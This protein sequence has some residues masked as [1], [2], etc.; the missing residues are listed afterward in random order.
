MKNEPRSIATRFRAYQLGQ[1]GSSFSHYANGHF[2]LIEGIIT[3]TNHQTLLDELK[4]CGKF[5]IDTL[6]ITS[7]DNDHCNNAAL[8]WIFDNLKPKRVEY[9]GY[10]PHTLT[11]HECRNT[12]KSYKK[13]FAAKGESITIQSIDPNYV[14]ALNKAQN[15]GYRD[16]VYHP[17][18]LYEDSNN[19]STIK[20][21]RCGSF[22]VLSLGD[23]KD[24]NISAMLRRCKILCREID[25]MILA[26][27]GADNGFTNQR[28]L[29]AVKPSIAIASSNYNNH[30][31]HPK[32]T[33]RELLFK[34]N[35]ELMTTKTGDVIAESI[36][37]H[38][39]KFQVTNMISN[40]TKIK[41][42]YIYTARK[43]KLLSMNLDSI[44]NLYN[45]GFKGIKAKR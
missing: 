44:R 11:A 41:D 38:R 32:E 30:H 35:I 12:I 26:H 2:T 23:V 22:N 20:F 4:L 34:M 43:A 40:S 39:S 19:N 15:L 25:V 14:N 5:N 16:I 24:Q 27:H 6:H 33:I 28:F 10:P 7:W 45:P 9:P 36:E 18:E 3:D 42:R 8:E 37:N 21:Y 13:K 31:E 17:R 29:E 1:A